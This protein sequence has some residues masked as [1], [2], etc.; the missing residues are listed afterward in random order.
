MLDREQ[1]Q[2]EIMAALGSDSTEERVRALLE[3][4]AQGVSVLPILLEILDRPDATLVTLVWTMMGIA[5]F[6]PHIADQA[7][8]YLVRSLAAFSPTVRR[9]AI[10]TLGTL[11]DVS[12]VDAIAALRTDSTLDPS[13]WFDDDCTVGQTAD[14]VIAEL[15]AATPAS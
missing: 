14:L 1:R 7:R 11:R 3:I 13:A 5:R 2:V 8:P 4:Q 9:S 6:G 10:R 12:A 15:Q